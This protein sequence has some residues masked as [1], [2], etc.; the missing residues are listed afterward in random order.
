MLKVSWQRKG[1]RDTEIRTLHDEPKPNNPN[2]QTK[3]NLI[4]C[5]EPNKGKKSSPT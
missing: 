2:Q 4:F 5:S 3:Q 1:K